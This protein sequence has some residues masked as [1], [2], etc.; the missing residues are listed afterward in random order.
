MESID[1]RPQ[2]VII[3]H[4]IILR[5]FAFCADNNRVY[6]VDLMLRPS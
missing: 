2:V 6:N 5:N 4:I 3:E 1:T